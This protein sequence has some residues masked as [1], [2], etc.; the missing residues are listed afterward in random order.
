VLRSEAQQHRDHAA[1]HGQNTADF[2]A[3]I[4]ELDEEI[5][6][7]RHV[8]KL[9]RNALGDAHRMEL[10]T[11]NVATQIKAP[12]LDREH[13][14]MLS[15]NEAKNLLRVIEGERLEAL[16]VLALTT[17]LRRGELVALRWDDINIS[18]RQLHVRRAM[19]RVDGHL[20]VVEP[21]TRS[22]L[23]AV[24][25]PRLAVRHLQEH[26]Q[27]QEDERREL[28]D[29]WQDHGLV[30]PSSIGT[31]IEPRNVNRRWDELRKKAGLD[32]LRLHDLRHG[33]A[34]F[35]LAQGVPP[36]AIME[37]LGHAEIGVTMNTSTHVL[38][39]LRQ[40]AADA[41]DELFGDL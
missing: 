19:Q 30:F 33:C 4:A 12:P 3:L 41:I 6:T 21:K 24:V 5:T 9:I 10:V 22:S 37:V 27:R 26:K 7:L 18:S 8:Y 34:T 35:L 38:P 2:D 32:W 25:L 15:V 16:Y 29:A 13:R 39:E 28:G 23:R 36:R 20:Q 11:R 31:P 1:D 40:E 14:P 17:V